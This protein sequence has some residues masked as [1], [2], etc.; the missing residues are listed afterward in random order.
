MFNLFYGESN[1]SNFLLC[2]MGGLL[3]SLIGVFGGYLGLSYF[4]FF[5]FGS[6]LS[7]LVNYNCGLSILII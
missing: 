1:G 4:V 7:G 6:M 5:Y 2:G 3:L